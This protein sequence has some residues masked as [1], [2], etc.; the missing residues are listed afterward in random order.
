MTCLEKQLEIYSDAEG[1][2]N[3][4][5]GY[6][7]PIC[8]N[9]GLVFSIRNEEL[10]SK[11]CECIKTRKSLYLLRESGIQEQIES[12]TLDS[13]KINNE[14]QMKMCEK[15]KSYINDNEDRWFFIGDKVAQERH[16]FAQ[17]Y[18]WS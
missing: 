9:K 6:D 15:A 4:N 8:K 3:K 13:F 5:D 18:V 17:P 10:V 11:R 1:D 7:C 14:W 2:M 12:K 16:I